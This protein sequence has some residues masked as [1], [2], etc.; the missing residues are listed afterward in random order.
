[1]IL[2]KFAATRRQGLKLLIY[3][4]QRVIIV[5]FKSKYRGNLL[6]VASRPFSLNGI[7]SRP[8]MSPLPALRFKS[9][10]LFLTQPRGTTTVG[11]S[12]PCMWTLYYHFGALLIWRLGDSLFLGWWLETGFENSIVTKKLDPS[13]PVAFHKI[14][15]NS[16]KFGII[17]LNFDWMRFCTVKNQKT[18]NRSN[19]P[20]NRTELAEIRSNSSKIRWNSRG[21]SSLKKINFNYAN[22]RNLK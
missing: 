11:L 5:R 3:C 16:A 4:L 10:T 13:D 6:S 20:I 7:F 1:M 2:P 14:L 17:R 21:Y 22:I 18:K 9:Y 15:Y 12:V 8:L 19:L